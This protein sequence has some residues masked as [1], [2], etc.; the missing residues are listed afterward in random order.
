MTF[1]AG[2]TRRGA[3]AAAAGLATGAA[4]SGRYAFAS[5]ST[6]HVGLQGLPDSLVMG[7]S[8]FAALNLA[9]QTQDALVHRDDV[10]RL[11]PGLA[12]A[13]RA[14][15][16]ST[17]QFDLRPN[18]KFHDGRP[19][20][21][22]DV[23]FTLDYILAPDSTYGT[24]ARISQI[25]SVEAPDERTILIKTKGPFP[26]LANGL[27][28]IPMEPKHYVEAVGRA[29]MTAK[30]MGTGP[31]RF[32]RWIPGDRYELTA[33]SDYWGGRPSVE[34]LVLRQIPE[35]STRVAAL[36]AGEIQI[37]EE[38]PV[39]LL[40]RVQKTRNTE[41]ADVESTVGLLLTFDTRKKPFDDPRVRL[42]LNYA[43]DK[44]K[45]LKRLLLD[46]GTL[47]Q[48]QPIT[49]N[50]FGFNPNVKAIPYDP[51]KAKALLAEAGYA[52][53]FETSITTRSGKYLADVEICNVCAAMFAEVG[54]KTAVNVVEQGVF[55]KMSSAM[56]MGP[57]HM[58]GWYSLGDADF[59]TVWFTEASRRAFWKSD[60]Y[61][62]LFVKARTTVEESGRLEAYHRMMEIMNAEVPSIFLFGLP[63]IYGKAKSL[64]NWSPPSD[65]I[66]RVAKAATS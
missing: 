1:S 30:P 4:L 44:E 36:L 35:G 33:F 7:F 19:F 5:A 32:K 9:L 43:V 64:K 6:L 24:K 10:G 40:E 18:V 48:G 55:S 2:L 51:A 14:I 59:A 60:E 57:M 31:F 50:T 47:L 17:W 28:D 61:E 37:A 53:G 29:G 16:A 3:I 21:S 66:L 34:E 42:A 22:A 12:T 45:I 25:A 58:V 15:D 54:V 46:R 13:W 39:D 23:K 63:S 49:S 62:K 41:V 20:T 52:K 27:S 26:T 56:D 11:I 38:L 8:S 65:K